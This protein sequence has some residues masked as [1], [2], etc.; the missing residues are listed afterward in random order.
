MSKIEDGT[1]AGNVA[2]VDTNKRLHV[3]SVVETESA[4]AGEVGDAY[5]INTGHIS[6]TGD[7]TLIYLKNNEDQDLIL[8]AIA[9]GTDGGGT[10]TSSLRPYVTLIKNP[11]AGDLLSDATAVSQN[12]NRN[13][14]SSKTL[15]ADSYKGKQGGTVTG[16]TD[17]GVFQTSQAGRDFFIINITI[18]K[19][20]SIALSVTNGLSSGTSKVYCALIVHLKDTASSN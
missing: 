19:G 14:G 11:T 9:L 6:F 20:S 10:Y 7:G 13:F 4:H 3:Q 5:N 15:T 16:G 12:V 2:K 18:P 8:E 17:F 1:G